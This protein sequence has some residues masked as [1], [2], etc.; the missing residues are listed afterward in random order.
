MLR[1]RISALLLIGLV[2]LTDSGCTHYQLGTSSA[3]LSFSSLYIEPVVSR[4]MVPQA[5]PLVSTQIRDNFEKDGRVS[6]VNSPEA[7]DA[8]LSVVLVGYD[9]E[10]SSVRSGDTGLARQ[11]AIHLRAEC[12]L[13]DRRT[14]QMLFD[15]RPIESTKYAYTDSGQLQSEYQTLPL[16]A[17]DLAGKIRHTVLDV[18]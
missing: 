8:V 13:T 3:K 5:Q 12:T 6:L 14:G 15:K 1:L 10:V 11:F 7:A 9:R 4:A 17:E 18:W 16:L 2:A